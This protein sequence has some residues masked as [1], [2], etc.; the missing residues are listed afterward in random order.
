[1][2]SKIPDTKKSPLSLIVRIILSFGLLVWIF[3]KIDMA[4]TW[5]VIRGA[6]LGYLIW[7]FFIF[8][9]LNLIVLL[10]WYVFI[11]AM[12]LPA[13]FRDVAKW[14]FIG[15]F[16]NLFLPSAVGGDVVKI[17]GLSKVVGQKPKIFASVVLDRLSGFAGIV[18]IASVMY[19]VGNRYIPDRSVGG[20]II[21]MA[22][23]SLLISSVLFS[24][25]IYSFCCRIFDRWPSV[26]ETLMK[27]HYDIAL[28]KGKVKEG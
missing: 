22:I 12:S 24:H 10:R 5:S 20:S 6:N 26:K 4:H 9:F 25:G 17:I 1:M 14:F 15:I 2:A 8:F 18:I 28:M 19:I 16:C 23:A 13:S 7:G 27:I 21:I 3:S 11:R